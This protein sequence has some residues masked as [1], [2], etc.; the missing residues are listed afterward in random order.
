VIQLRPVVFAAAESALASSP[1][2]ELNPGD[3]TDNIL[4]VPI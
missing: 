1:A 4:L 2:A 3:L